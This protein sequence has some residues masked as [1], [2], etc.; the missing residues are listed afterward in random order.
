[1]YA[2]PGPAPSLDGTNIVFGR[3]LEGL[4]TVSAVARVPTFKPSERIRFYNSV[5]RF[6]GDG[7]ADQA[8]RQ[9]GKPLQPVLITASG[10]MT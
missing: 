3:V 4:D 6:L 8:Q 10:M 1:M 9:W 2:G 7:R 5:A